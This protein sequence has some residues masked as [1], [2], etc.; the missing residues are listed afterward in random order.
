[1]SVSI[2]Q[3]PIALVSRLY[4]ETCTGERPIYSRLDFEFRPCE[5]AYQRA[6]PRC[7][8]PSLKNPV[9]YPIWDVCERESTLR[10]TVGT[11]QALDPE[12]VGEVGRVS[13]GRGGASLLYG[14]HS[15]DPVTSPQLP[16]AHRVLM[17]ASDR[18]DFPYKNS[19]CERSAHAPFSRPSPKIGTEEYLKCFVY[20][21]NRTKDWVVRG[22]DSNRFFRDAC[23]LCV[24]R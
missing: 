12:Q 5:E 18:Q 6:Y 9:Y 14:K 17:L 4:S 7:P 1:M 8:N 24:R 19:V 16:T 23:E 3:R 2:K 15:V 10:L 22:H 11:M 13:L 21:E 20:G